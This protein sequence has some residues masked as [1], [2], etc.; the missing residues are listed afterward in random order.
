MGRLPFDPK[1]VSLPP[2]PAGPGKGGRSAGERAALSVTQVCDLVQDLLAEHAP[3]TVR[4]VGEI[5]NF[6]DRKHWYFSLKDQQSVIGCVMW[7]RAAGRCR[8]APGAGQ[9]VVASGKLGFYGPQGRTQLYVENL[10]PVGKGALELRF[11]QLCDE[12][13]RAGYF[14][15]AQKQPLPPFP[16][17]LAVITSARGAALQDVVRTARQRWGGIRLSL[18]DVRVQG[19][20]AAG[21]IAAA[22]R[23]VDRAHRDLGIDA[24]I[25]TRGGG[26]LEDLWAF[27]EKVVATALRRCR[28]P[29]VAAVGH[30]TDTTIAELVA[31]LRCSTPTQAAARLVP[32]ASAEAQRI[33]QLALRVRHGARQHL[34]Q[35]SLQLDALAR[36]LQ[37]AGRER[38]SKSIQRVARVQRGLDRLAA[39]SLVRLARERLGNLSARLGEA[40]ASR[41]VQAG[42][43][44]DNLERQLRAVDPRGVL[45]RGYSYTT[46]DRGR[47]VRR[48][49]K[50]RVGQ[51]LTTHLVDG[52]VESE[53]TGKRSPGKRSSE[54]RSRARQGSRDQGRL[55]D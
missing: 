46:D 30:E 5:S 2:E 20:A 18:L 11:R 34:R 25:L 44:T 51:V 32:D 7:A 9:E 26:S 47:V 50:V 52:Q 22:I 15:E 14:D 37:A 31:D 3:A 28:V 54:G 12:L 19:T 35:G 49:G 6:T 48:A 29:V 53:V 10:E 27:N 16:R 13:R 42:S 36:H 45:S 41:L 17:H 39:P 1:K 43:A 24:V 4:V 23:A 55:F 40:A 33:G 8:F 38:V 21:Q